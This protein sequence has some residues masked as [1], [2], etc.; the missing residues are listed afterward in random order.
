[1]NSV[2]AV[3]LSAEVFVYPVVMMSM[4]ISPVVGSVADYCKA[5]L[6]SLTASSTSLFS[7]YSDSR[8]L[9]RAS[10]ILIMDSS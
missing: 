2:R 8:I 10:E 4:L 6:M 7:T 5:C 1:M 3:S 9:A